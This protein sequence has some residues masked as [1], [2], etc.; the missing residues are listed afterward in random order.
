MSC[1]Y[2]RQNFRDGRAW[3]AHLADP[4]RCGQRPAHP[5]ATSRLAP[6][7][8]DTDDSDADTGLAA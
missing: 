8:T 4:W 5:A 2:C 7:K 3:V 6:A 1:P